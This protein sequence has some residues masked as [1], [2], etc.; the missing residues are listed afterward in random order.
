MFCLQISFLLLFKKI[1]LMCFRKECTWPLTV[2][3]L[4]HLSV[5][6]NACKHDSGRLCTFALPSASI[7]STQKNA[8]TFFSPSLHCNHPSFFSP[9]CMKH[10]LRLICSKNLCVKRLLLLSL[11]AKWFK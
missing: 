6:R 10:N 5:S 3:C 9:R 11:I 4:F 8:R 7:L 1:I 2:Q